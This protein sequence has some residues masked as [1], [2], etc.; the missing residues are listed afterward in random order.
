MILPCRCT[1]AATSNLL[2]K[3]MDENPLNLK[4]LETQ[5]RITIQRILQ[6]KDI[7]LL[8]HVHRHTNTRPTQACKCNEK[9]YC[10][11]AAGYIFT[12]VPLQ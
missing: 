4:G 12:Y 6:R 5:E 2:F 11:V 7:Q 9:N 10:E 1:T 3:Q 8:Q